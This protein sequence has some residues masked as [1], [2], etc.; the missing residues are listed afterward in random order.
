M[1][2][3]TIWVGLRWGRTRELRRANE[4]VWFLMEGVKTVPAVQGPSLPTFPFWAS[5]CLGCPPVWGWGRGEV[6]GLP[7]G[8]EPS[9]WG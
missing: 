8:P 4:P 3:C 6:E 9:V 5:D 2:R 1:S 7:G